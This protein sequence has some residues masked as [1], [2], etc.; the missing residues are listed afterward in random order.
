MSLRAVNRYATYVWKEQCPDLHVILMEP[1][2]LK[3]L[4]REFGITVNIML[5]PD[6][7]Q[8]QDDSSRCYPQNSV[9]FLG[10]GTTKQPS[11]VYNRSLQNKVL[12]MTL[13]S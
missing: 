2:R 4:G 1:R 13:V 9:C 5:R 11:V 12:K 7:S 10:G 3:D 6:P 8:A